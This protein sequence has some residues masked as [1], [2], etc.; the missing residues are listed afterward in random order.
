MQLPGFQNNTSSSPPAPSSL[1]LASLGSLTITEHFEDENG[2]GEMSEASDPFSSIIMD[3]QINSNISSLCSLFAQNNNIV[4]QM[5]ATAM[6][7][8]AAQIGSTS[9]NNNNNNSSSLAY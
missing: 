3:D 2:D 4:P 1:N 6:L 7:Q 5:S 9:S 8:E